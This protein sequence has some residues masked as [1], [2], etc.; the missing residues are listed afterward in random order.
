MFEEEERE[1]LRKEVYDAMGEKEEEKKEQKEKEKKKDGE[2]MEVAMDTDEAK[3][4]KNDE[5]VEDDKSKEKDAKEVKDEKKKEDKKKEDKDETS[6]KEEKDGTSDKAKVKEGEEK[7]DKKG[8]CRLLQVGLLTNT[9]A[10]N[11]LPC[12]FHNTCFLFQL[13]TDH[14]SFFFTA[15]ISANV[16]Y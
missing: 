10:E 9:K 1:K 16:A 6:E 12:L 14:C 13:F 2:T 8:Y 15:F 7:S 5:K 4:E 3:A 11:L